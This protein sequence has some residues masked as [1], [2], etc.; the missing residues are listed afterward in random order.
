[1]V[2]SPRPLAH[3]AELGKG[4]ELLMGGAGSLLGQGPQKPEWVAPM[5]QPAQQQSQGDWGEP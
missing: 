3:P 1:M 5:A 2:L 4:Q